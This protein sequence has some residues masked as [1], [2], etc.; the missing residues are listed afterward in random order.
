MVDYSRSNYA[1][2]PAT[3][4]QS[5]YQPTSTID[6]VPASTGRQPYHQPSSSADQSRMPPPDQYN[7]PRPA[8]PESGRSSRPLSQDMSNLALQQGPR[9]GTPRP[10]RTSGTYQPLVG[11]FID[12]PDPTVPAHLTDPLPPPP[13]RP[14]DSEG[15][16]SP[17]R[18]SP[19]SRPAS[20][21]VASPPA[22]VPP[23]EYEWETEIDGQRQ[24][25]L[26]SN[27]PNVALS[28]AEKVYM[29]VSIS[30]EE[31]RR[32]RSVAGTDAP[33]P[34][35]PSYERGLREDCTRIVEKFVKLGNPKAVLPLLSWEK[36]MG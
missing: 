30:M 25:A 35:S 28:W 19:R 12:M 26:Q 16:Q 8:P 17:G 3:G 20:G 24:N 1:N 9:Q 23:S 21:A 15:R 34:S 14:I 5:Y 11:D 31:M 2:A 6:Q 32:E 33:Q 36:L 27:D 29:Y 10:H 22:M 7:Y 13:S 18:Q 4:R